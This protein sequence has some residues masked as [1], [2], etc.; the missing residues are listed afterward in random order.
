MPIKYSRKDFPKGFTFGVA[1]AAYQIE[2]SE[3]GSCGTSHWDTFS[4]TPGNVNNGENGSIACDHFH[5]FEEDLDLVK[6]GGFDSYRFSTSW[7]RVMP[8]GKTINKDGL[9]YYDRLVDAI[10]ER[11]LL[12]NLTLYHWELPSALADIGGLANRETAKR[13]VDHTNAVIK[14]I[15]DRMDAVATI[16]EP[17]CVAWLVTLGHH[18]PGLRDIRAAARAM[19]HVLL[20]H[21]LS[22][23]AMR[24]L[25]TSNIGIVLNLTEV[26]QAS[27]TQSDVSA[28]IA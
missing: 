13:F 26:Q 20:A 12:P 5:R 25:G 3:N 6:A 23:D 9:D 24:S 4:T 28:K 15:G 18:A 16:N 22:I 19:H 11:N 7:A 21:G 27:D 1:T 10:C 17:W 8:D 2:G 14:C